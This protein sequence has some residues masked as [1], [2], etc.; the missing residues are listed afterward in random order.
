M[1]QQW[2]EEM[3]SQQTP[4]LEERPGEAGVLG[5][6]SPAQDTSAP[7][8][9]TMQ[10]GPWPDPSWSRAAWAGQAGVQT[11]CGCRS[12]VVP[13]AGLLGVPG[14]GPLCDPATLSVPA[15]PLVCSGG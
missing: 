5:P 7:S 15:I 10:K 14:R 13:E 2:G 11:R 3:G 8:A 9:P 1:S 4:V 6:S 12:R